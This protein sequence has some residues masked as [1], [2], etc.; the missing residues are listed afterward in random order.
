MKCTKCNENEAVCTE[1]CLV[2]EHTET[3]RGF[4]KETN[5]RLSGV[6]TVGLCKK[7]QKKAARE[8]VQKTDSV[9]PL[10]WVGAAIGIIGTVMWIIGAAQ[11]NVC[12]FIIGVII[13]AI[14]A[15]LSYIDH[16]MI[17]PNNLI[18]KKPYLLFPY[19]STY[20]EK[21]VPYK[22]EYYK[23]YNS[24]N[25]LNRIGIEQTSKSSTISSNPIRSLSCLAPQLCPPTCPTTALP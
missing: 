13:F 8:Q 18:K 4:Q 10:F 12:L 6:K 20:K 2:V 9:S 5:E 7:C 25:K 11:E 3:I 19:A 24:F 16:R 15:S 14:G 21:Y 1:N 22:K 23:D 17:G